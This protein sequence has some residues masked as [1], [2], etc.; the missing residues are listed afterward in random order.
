MRRGVWC[1]GVVLLLGTPVAADGQS[2]EGSGAES[3]SAPVSAPVSVP[4]PAPVPVPAP[5]SVS[6]LVAPVQG[7]QG[8]RHAYADRLGGALGDA[9][10]ERGYTVVVDKARGK[11]LVACGALECIEQTVEGAGAAFAVVPA[12]WVRAGDRR[13]LTLTLVGKSGR[14]LNAGTVINGDLRRTAADLLD[15]LLTRRNEL[16]D[17]TDDALATDGFAITVA[18]GA[19]VGQARST[20]TVAAADEPKQEPTHPHAWKAGPIVLWAG[21]VGIFV[22]IGA[23]AGMKNENQQLNKG[24][25]AAWSVVGAAAFAGGTAWWVV[26]EKRRRSQSER[27]GAATDTAIRVSPSGIDLRLRF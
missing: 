18:G 24:A 1:W 13:E 20:S 9:L 6:V 17:G 3:V 22:G 23:A 8:V 26:G 19:P 11:A 27:S 14:N 4:A 16:E 10:E 15:E 5:V 2:P 25:V 7:T 12:M 21:G